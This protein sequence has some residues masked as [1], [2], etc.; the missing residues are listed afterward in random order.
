MNIS[1]E[2]PEERS[3]NRLAALR[4]SPWSEE[5]LKPNGDHSLDLQNSRLRPSQNPNRQQ[6]Y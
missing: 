5:N 3:R 1:P 4:C 2:L 6:R